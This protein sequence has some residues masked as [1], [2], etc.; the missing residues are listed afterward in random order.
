MC[1]ILLSACNLQSNSLSIVRVLC[2]EFSNS[3]NG[4]SEALSFTSEEMVYNDAGFVNAG[5]VD[6]CSSY[7]S[8]YGDLLAT[9]R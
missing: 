3:N 2:V 4:E 8:R 6:G 7:A 1:A 9:D 5:Y